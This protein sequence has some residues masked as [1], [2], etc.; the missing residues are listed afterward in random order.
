MHAS[1]IT[2]HSHSVL[3][4]QRFFVRSGVVAVK[5]P[6][7]GLAENLAFL[8]TLRTLHQLIWG[9]RSPLPFMILVNS[10]K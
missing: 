9:I 6:F 3:P 10:T 5:I 2:P 8:E 1:T 7:L 4:G